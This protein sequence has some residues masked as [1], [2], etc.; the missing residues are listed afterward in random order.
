MGD[1]LVGFV[2]GH[3]T[4][5]VRTVT[6]KWDLIHSQKK[7]NKIGEYT[8]EIIFEFYIQTDLRTR[9]VSIINSV[10][11]FLTSLFLS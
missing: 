9:V 10:I 6:V 5:T 8:D 4:N 2:F 7:V 1:L 11:K 3:R